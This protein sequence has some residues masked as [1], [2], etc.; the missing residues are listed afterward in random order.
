MK[1]SN[2]GWNVLA[3]AGVVVAVPLFGILGFSVL[4]RD[5][6]SETKGPVSRERATDCPMTLPPAAHDIQYASFCDGWQGAEQ[7]V[8]FEAPVEECKVFAEQTLAKYVGKRTDSESPQLSP[9]RHPA[10]PPKWSKLH[11][12]WFDVEAIP[13]GLMSPKSSRDAQVWVDTK[14]GI[15]YFYLSH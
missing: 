2:F 6:I 5:I 13:E 9:A 12:D 4:F 7:Y 11:T 8:R 1:L 10:R 14:R 3:A 15:F